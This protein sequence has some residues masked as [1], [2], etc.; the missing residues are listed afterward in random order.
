MQMNNLWHFIV[1][2]M[3]FNSFANIRTYFYF[4]FTLCEYGMINSSGFESAFR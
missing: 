4:I 2:K 3:A 1:I